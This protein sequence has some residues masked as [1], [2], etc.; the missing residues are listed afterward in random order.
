[1]QTPSPSQNGMMRALTR[2]GSVSYNAVVLFADDAEVSLPSLKEGQEQDWE[3]TD[4]RL[5]GR[6][7][8]NLR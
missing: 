8:N 6:I 5:Q 2:S 3:A 1:M 7:E 4:V